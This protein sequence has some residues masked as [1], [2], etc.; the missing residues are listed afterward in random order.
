[1][2]V[3]S[4]F[5]NAR[6]A[7][8]GS[9]ACATRTHPLADGWARQAA[10]GLRKSARRL[11]PVV[12]VS[13]SAPIE[14]AE[15]DITSALQRAGAGVPDAMNGLFPLVYSTLKSIAHREC[16]RH[17]GEALTTTALVH[18]TYLDLVGRAPRQWADRGQFYAYA[19]CAMRSILVDSARRRLALKR[20][21]DRI[22]D[23]DADDELV[24]AGIDADLVGLDEALQR[25]AALDPALVRLVE[26]RYF[27]GLPVPRVAE[28]LG[29]A[30]RSVDRLWQKARMLLAQ[31]LG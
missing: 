19:G 12:P 7:T 30:P 2:V 10:H 28:L 16:R 1:M 9:T 8:Q 13:A 23:V 6:A 17:A 21:G 25:L 5:D 18:E 4:P 11:L 22:E 26:L 20:G 31:Y 14:T 27:A 24:V 29:I 15:A 3:A